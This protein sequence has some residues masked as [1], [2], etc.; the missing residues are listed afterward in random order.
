MRLSLPS[1]LVAGIHIITPA[2]SAQS[3]TYTT[4]GS[5]CP[6]DCVVLPTAYA[7]KMGQLA[8]TFPHAQFNMRYQQVFLGSE[9]GGPRVLTELCLRLDETYGGPAQVQTIELLLGQTPKNPADLVTT[10]TSNY[11]TTPPTTVFKGTLN[12]PA[13]TNGGGIGDFKICMKFTAAWIWLPIPNQNLLTEWVNTSTASTAHF[14][15]K[16]QLAPDCTTTRMW[17]TSATATV[18]VGTE[19]NAGLVMCLRTTSGRAPVLSNTGVP[20]IA[21]TFSVD[22]S[23]ARAQ[24]AAGLIL[25]A[26]KTVWGA[27]T[28]P[29]ALAPLGAPGCA[30]LAS[31]DVLIGAATD[32]NGAASLPLAIPNAPSLVSVVFHNQ[33]FVVDQNANQLG[34]AWSNG[35]TATIGR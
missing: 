20:A 31:F 24:T 18:A 26:S 9:I 5:G 4:F 7:T 23:G 15:D 8:N 27:F 3:G 29:L 19:R 33:W 16:C 22:L 10:F 28:L 6:A 17:A 34:A 11:G 14:E 2:V 35:G 32:A 30:L 13:H 25:G 12:L 21:R 1:V